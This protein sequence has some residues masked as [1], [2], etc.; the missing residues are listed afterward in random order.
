MSY[1][2]LPLERFLE[3]LAAREPVPGG[4]GAAAVSVALGAA[5]AA[6]AA[7]YSTGRLDDADELAGRADELRA[8]VQPLI[9]KDAAAYSRVLEIYRSAERSGL[10]GALSAAADV[11]LSIA[12]AGAEVSELGVMIAE[13]GNPNLRGDAVTAVLLAESG[14]RAAGLLVDLNLDLANIEDERRARCRELV[15]TAEVARERVLKSVTGAGE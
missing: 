4:G 1:L 8:E 15:A 3:A 6:M 7:R 5:L 11:P 13:Q 12:S 9:D 10:N 14:A 2:E